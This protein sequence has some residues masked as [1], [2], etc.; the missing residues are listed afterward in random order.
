MM[1]SIDGRLIGERW[2]PSGAAAVELT[3][4]ELGQIDNAAS[5]IAVHGARYP[6][7]LEKRTGL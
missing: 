1:R 5:T 7:A 4:E 2:S 6:E 3:T